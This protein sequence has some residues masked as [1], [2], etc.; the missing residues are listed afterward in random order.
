MIP[1]CTA[2]IVE[3]IIQT[4]GAIDLSMLT[5]LAFVIC[6]EHLFLMLSLSLAYKADTQVGGLVSG[7]KGVV[8]MQNCPLAFWHVLN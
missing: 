4:L 8:K 6:S 1:D 2:V 5:L 7:R 3:V